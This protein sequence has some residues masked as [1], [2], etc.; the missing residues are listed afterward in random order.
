M[1]V[2]V[3]LGQRTHSGSVLPHYVISK[4]VSKDN[5]YF[6]KHHSTTWRSWQDHDKRVVV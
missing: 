3:I 1:S 2:E 6:Q 5:L 4:S